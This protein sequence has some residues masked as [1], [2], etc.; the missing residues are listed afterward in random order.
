[1]PHENAYWLPERPVL[2]GEYPFARDPIEG[3]ARLR[4]FLDAGVGSF[5]DLTEAGEYVLTPY[6]PALRELA[7]ERGIA[8]EYRR[9]AIPDMGVPQPARMAEILDAIDAACAAGQS[10]YVHCWG[11]V[12]RTG[13]V[14]AC[15]LVRHGRAAEDAFALVGALFATMSPA[16]RGRHPWGSPQTDEQREFVRAWHRH[17]AAARRAPG[18]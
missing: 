5:I 15:H 8:V 4:A 18:A 16:K 3:R 13:T 1:V 12:G 10:V 17:D 7:A 6:E 11:G 14:V 9:L 2:A